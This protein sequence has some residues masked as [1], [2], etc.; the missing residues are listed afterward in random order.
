ML[1]LTTKSRFRNHP[2]WLG[3]ALVAAMALSV[4]L[5]PALPAQARDPRQDRYD[6]KVGGDRPGDRPVVR[7]EHA[8]PRKPAVIERLPRG[9]ITV[10]QGRDDYFYH[11]GHYFRR[12]GVGFIAILPPVGLVVPIL[13]PGYT[14]M[15]VTGS[16]YYFY[17][18]V[19]YRQ[20]PTGFVVVAPPPTMEVPTPPP[21]PAPAYGSISITAAA[22][23]VRSGPGR[24]HPVMTVIQRGETY[25]VQAIAPGWL[26]IQLPDGR[27]GWVEQ[28]HTTP[29]ATVPAG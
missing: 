20:A 11:H 7:P 10:R 3:L 17:E 21:A 22:L 5:P 2:S 12:G 25:P 24:E 27:F 29:V 9:H 13:P 8:A 1:Y 26:Y 16:P 18:G 14:T 4:L 6:Q 15:V 28:M 23:N 19:Y